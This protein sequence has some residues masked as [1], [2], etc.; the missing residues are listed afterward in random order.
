MENSGRLFGQ[1][2]AE[3]GVTPNR[4]KLAVYLMGLSQQGRTVDYAAGALRKKPDT[5]K[6]YAR[7]FLIDFADY[8]PFD[9][10]RAKGVEIE[11]K[12]L[13]SVRAA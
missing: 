1:I 10:K 4:A 6:T 8:R 11:P 2:A 9:K 13:L 7:E 5:I 12:H 3:A